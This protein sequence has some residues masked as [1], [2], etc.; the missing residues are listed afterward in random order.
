MAPYIPKYVSPEQAARD[1]ARLRSRLYWFALILPVTFAILMFGYSDQAPA[2]LR[3]VTIT[4]DRSLG[5]PI[6]NLISA[7]ASR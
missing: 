1:R 2:V 5:Y 7:I 6:L 3:T 4:L